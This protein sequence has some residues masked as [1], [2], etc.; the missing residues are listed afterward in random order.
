MCLTSSEIFGSGDV[1]MRQIVTIIAIAMAIIFWVWVYRKQKIG[2]RQ[3]I[4]S[5][6]LWVLFGTLDIVITAKGTFYNPLREGNPFARAI[7]VY[8]GFL[9]PAVASILWISFWAGIVFVINKKITRSYSEFLSLAIFYSLAVGHFFGFGSWFPPL[10][11]VVSLVSRIIVDTPGLTINIII[12]C[13][14]AAI[15]ML[16][17]RLMVAQDKIKSPTN[18]R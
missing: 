8:I 13:A 10:C 14:F 3:Y 2:L 4:I 18:K 16:M 1:L 6:A 11:W 7:F 12:G 17:V 15:N 5:I 9:G